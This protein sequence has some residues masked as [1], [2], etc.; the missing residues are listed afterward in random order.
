MAI[1][2]ILLFLATGFLLFKLHK[3]KQVSPLF[4]LSL[5]FLLCFWYVIPVLLT[6]I[7]WNTLAE[8]ALR[9]S[10]YGVSYEKYIGICSLE[11]FSL[12]LTCLFLFIR[13]PYFGAIVNS[14]LAHQKVGNAVALA[15]LLVGFAL[16]VIYDVSI[17]ASVG[18]SY[19]ERNSFLVNEGD[20]GV[21]GIIG[22]LGAVKEFVGCFTFAC[23]LTRWDK[24]ASSRMIFW[25]G[26]AITFYITISGVL[27][28]SRIM[29]LTP[30]TL[31]VL[32]AQTNGQWSRR[33][34]LRMIGIGVAATL[35]L[36]SLI[37]VAV[38]EIRSF[39]EFSASDVQKGT[40]ARTDTSFQ[41]QWK[42]SLEEIV[43][44][45]NSPLCGAI[46]LDEGMNAAGFQPYW[47]AVLALV[48]RFI[49]PVKP[50]TGSANDDYTGHPTRIVAVLQGQDAAAGNVQVSPAAISL[51][52]LGV[53][54]LI[55]LLIFNVLNFYLVN[56]L[57]LSESLLCR[58]L[59]LSVVWLPVFYTLFSSADNVIQTGQ[60]IAIVL[61]A[62][63]IVYRIGSVF[64]IRKGLPVSQT[65]PSQTT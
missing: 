55:L 39:G 61:I 23:L 64:L 32:Y 3:R 10:D 51:W 53:W 59:G 54:G 62:A 7:F 30:L 41:E 12:L 8:E 22:T 46:L 13:R 58:T 21:F 20:T 15:G 40:L 50:V 11:V 29:V 25:L 60:R 38:G 6:V 5:F 57:L 63:A 18:T 17:G 45:F 27:I 26:W 28:G 37:G 24:S 33:K 65:H 42:R 34:K 35:V 48:P 9:I 44:K 49:M 43:I 56:S 2:P 47:G 16:M 1:L 19:L 4:T 36:G 31:L 14:R 52:Q